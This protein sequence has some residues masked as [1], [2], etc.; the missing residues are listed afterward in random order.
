MGRHVNPVAVFA[1]IMFISVRIGLWYV[2]SAAIMVVGLLLT[3]RTF[4]S[5]GLASSQS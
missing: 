2:G 5:R 4:F 1:G 3:A